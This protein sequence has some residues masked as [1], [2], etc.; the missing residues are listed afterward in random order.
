M[1]DTQGF[2]VIV[3]ATPALLTKELR[4][5]WK[6]AACPLEPGDA[7]RIP[8]NIDIEEADN[9]S[10][11]GYIVVDGQ[12]RLPQEE[13]DAGL[14]PDID[15]AELKFGL[16]IQLEIKDPPVPSAAL[17]DMRA[18]VR[19]RV[20]VR[21]PPGEKG[22]FI[23][24]GGLPRDNVRAVLTSGDPL[25]PK[26][27][28][29]IREYVH[30]LYESNGETFPHSVTQTNL[31]WN[32]VV[33]MVMIDSYAE[34]Y[35]DL[36]D[37]AHAIVV[38]GPASGA[39]TISIP[40]YLRIY[41]IRKSGV[42]AGFITI[43]DPMGVETRIVITAPF[44][45]P[46]GLIRAHFETATVAVDP[47]QPAGAIHGPEGA[48][49]ATNKAT[50]AGL[51]LGGVNLDTLL[52]TELRQQGEAMAAEIGLKE[53]EVPTVAEIEAAIATFF[54][55]DLER[56][57]RISVWTPTD[58]PEVELTINDVQSRV[59]PSVLA[60]AINAG[61]G[62]NIDTLGDFVPGG[63]EFAIQLSRGR[64]DAAISKS[65]E[66]N[67]LT[68]ADLPKRMNAEDHDV[69]LKQL[70]VFLIDS[71]IRTTGKV[72]V[73]DAI[74]GSIDVDADFRSDIGLEWE[75]LPGG[76]QRMRDVPQGEP[77]IDPEESVAMWVIGLIL[78]ILTG[79][80]AGG[81]IALII[82][83]IIQTVI[84]NVVQ[85]VGG[86]LVT[87]E[88]SGEVIGMSGWPARLSRIGFVRTRFNNPIVVDTTGLLM[89]GTVEVI[90]SC[91]ATAIAF[92]NS[93]GSYTAN[94]ASALIMTAHKTH[95]DAA[96]SW[97]AGD[98]SP[99][100]A[101]QDIIHSYAASGFYIA[102]HA[103]SVEQPGGVRTR[104]FA[105]VT[106]RNVPPSSVDAGPDITVDEGEVVTL[107]G[108][109]RD[110]EY[111]DTHETSWTFGDDQAPK[112]GTVS[113]TNVPP[114]AIGSST[115]THAW[116]DNG[117][118][119][120][121][122]TVRDQNGGLAHDT[123]TATVLNVPPKVDAG[124]DM[125]AYIC[126][127]IVLVARFEDAGWCDT[128]SAVW[129]FG[130]CS[131]AQTAIVEERHEPPAAQGTATAA[132]IYAFC[133]TFEASCTVTDDDGAATSDTTRIE[134]TAI[135]NPGFEGGFRLFG[136]SKVGN[137]WTPYADLSRYR[138]TI[139][140]PSP[141]SS[142]SGR[143][144]YACEEC[145]VH[146]GQR[147]QRVAPQPSP[148]RAPA[149]GR[150]SAPIPAGPT[151]LAAGCSLSPA[152]PP[153][154]GSTRAAATTRWRH[155]S[156]GFRPKPRTSGCSSADGSLLRGMGQRRSPSFSRSNAMSER[157]LAI[158]TMS[159]SWRC[160][161]SA[162]QPRRRT[163]DSRLP[164]AV[165]ART[166]RTSL[167]GGGSGICRSAASNFCQCV[168][169][170]SCRSSSTG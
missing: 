83:V 92:A 145:V 153:G 85:S 60:I 108:R 29:L 170:A 168:K 23:I 94:A 169:A 93:G 152:P 161:T 102:K 63:Q 79:G 132:H 1:A 124:P 67:D 18:D 109:F 122:F 96:Y 43:I 3:E 117:T 84:S 133:G 103:L 74:L 8:E 90:S 164:T 151:R 72:T 20:P 77:D 144:D 156:A 31:S 146:D 119:V 78:G 120:V 28:A 139:G 147:A 7:G 19:A 129:D 25:L 34:I 48:N 116:C 130:D 118:Y 5:A 55:A 99:A 16:H 106:V 104:H 42:G 38:T 123:L 39:V 61:A 80:L 140:G 9:F 37:P 58:A 13:L 27:N 50:L 69:D 22:V 21:V 91:E 107:V 165:P 87:D 121:T 33:A 66:D 30:L 154:W 59:F 53:I 10:V 2:D 127:P 158:W 89:A 135:D 166:L 71:A 46:P 64:V 125:F 47:I 95:P 148:D 32:F 128:H 24:L 68:A 75:D 136:T 26:H 97:F 138:A 150:S 155:G 15:G 142:A 44:E 141:S 57:N 73:I 134:V 6:S 101:L 167:P 14:A 131:G 35:D 81:V 137:G 86:S 159:S 45:T 105:A 149:S 36:A 70:D 98:G 88:I 40:V 111:R 41:N 160:R 115:V 113:E 12:V 82:L 110:I 4:G 54:H 162:R 52:Q 163:P 143:G 49:Y 62:A 114:Q 11:G 17:F 126:T 56:R 112:P 76:V 100:Q 157:L 51:P 65:L